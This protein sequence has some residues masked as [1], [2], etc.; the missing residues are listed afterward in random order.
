MCDEC[1]LS[2]ASAEPLFRRWCPLCRFL[3]RLVGDAI[4]F[5]HHSGRMPQIAADGRS[6]GKGL[7]E[8][9]RIDGVVAREEPRV[10]EMNGNFHYVGERRSARFQDRQE[11][12]DGQIGLRF[13]RI[14][15]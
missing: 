15:D 6:N 12:V 10:V 11:I 2:S 14:A 7:R 8:S 3:F 13:N 9:L 1:V 5:D 4:D